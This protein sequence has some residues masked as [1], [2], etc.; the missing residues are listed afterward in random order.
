MPSSSPAR[1]TPPAVPRLATRSPPP[2]RDQRQERDRDH[3]LR[4]SRPG[5]P[6]T[7]PLGVRPCRAE[8]LRRQPGDRGGVGARRPPLPRPPR[9]RRREPA[10][11]PCRRPGDRHGA[12]GRDPP[13]GS[14]LRALTELEPGE[15]WLVEPR[16]LDDGGAAWSPGV[17]LGVQPGSWFHMTECFGP[18]LGVLR[19]PDLDHAVA[20]QNM[21]PFGLTGGIH[22]LDPAE[23]AQ[24]LERGRGR[25]RLRQPR[26]HRRDRPAPAVRRLEALG[27][28]LDDQGRWPDHVASLGRWS[29]AQVPT[30]DGADD[31]ARVWDEMRA[32]SDPTG[33]RAERNL[34]RYRPLR[35]VLLRAGDDVDDRQ[36]DAAMVAA[37]TVGVQVELSTPRR[38]RGTRRGPGRRER[39]GA[40]R[41]GSDGD[42]RR[43]PRPGCSAR[44]GRRC[45]PRM[46]TLGAAVDTTAAIAVARVELVHWS[47]AQAISE[48]LH[49]HGHV[50]ARPDDRPSRHRRGLAYLWHRCRALH[51]GSSGEMRPIQTWRG[52]TMIERRRIQA[53]VHHIDDF[54]A[55][56][57][58][59]DLQ[60]RWRDEIARL[61]G[62]ARRSTGASPSPAS[63]AP[64]ASTTA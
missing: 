53:S 14:L 2:R 62:A 19:A 37:A 36:L 18:V 64:S 26:H 42:G 21:P 3:R 28:R 32:G 52:K 16:R 49:R 50:R 6:R 29:L 13:T 30:G 33:L 9:R 22:S 58:S 23:V 31:D 15:R 24:W 57:P 20:W 34:L 55:V 46:H 54:C 11:R 17:R 45:S 38:R 27:G 1:T 56:A 39:R 48:T 7:G 41:P 40:R 43:R 25:Q 35:R 4:R 47:R 12:A 61:R 8:V 10:P 5:D 60:D 63:R 51:F 59:P 44:P